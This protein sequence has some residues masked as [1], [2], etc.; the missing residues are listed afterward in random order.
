M[1]NSFTIRPSRG[2]GL[3][4][5]LGEFREV[6]GQKESLSAATIYF[7]KNLFFIV[8]GVRNVPMFVEVRGQLVRC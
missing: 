6:G 5:T 4:N 1:V 8:P 3:L 2:A 7:K